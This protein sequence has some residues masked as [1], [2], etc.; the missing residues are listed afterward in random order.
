MAKR[1]YYSIASG[2]SGNCGLYMAEGTAI[3]IDLGVSLRKITTALAGLGLSLADISAVL[4]THEHIDHVKGLPMLTK[5]TQIPVFASRGTAEALA[6]KDPL[7]RDRLNVFDAGADFWVKDVAVYS[8]ETP[9]DAANSVGYIL[10]QKDTRF[11]YATDLGFVPRDAAELLRG[12]E[13]VV[14]ESNH[15]PHMLQAGP[16]PYTLKMRVAGPTGHLSNPDCAVFAAD[17]VKNGTK[18][19]ILAHLSEKNNM[20]ELALQQTRAALC[21]LPECEVYV[22]SSDCM[23][24]P[25]VF[26]EEEVCSLFG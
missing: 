20:P 12:C 16:Y 5:K 1:Y 23:A 21:G 25:I 18:T 14:L 3:L 4:L 19:L 17:L 26:G 22:A 24:E 15:D 13:M 8:F 9:H 10:E 6:Q 11:G 7:C 2:S